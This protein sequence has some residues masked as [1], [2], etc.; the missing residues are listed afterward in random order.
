MIRLGRD[1]RAL[2]DVYDVQPT[3]YGEATIV[4]SC[5]HYLRHVS[6]QIKVGD[7]ERCQECPK[8]RAMPREAGTR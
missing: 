3:A 6:E 5:G 7:R 8:K 4:L 2:R 1:P